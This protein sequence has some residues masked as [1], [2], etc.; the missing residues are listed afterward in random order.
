MVN[1]ES[2]AENTGVILGDVVSATVTVQI[3]LLLN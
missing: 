3:A 2:V 1:F